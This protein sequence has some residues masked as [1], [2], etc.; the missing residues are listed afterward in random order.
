MRVG[1]AGCAFGFA[2]GAAARFR[3][4]GLGSVGR[5]LQRHRLTAPNHR[6]RVVQPAHSEFSDPSSGSGAAGEAQGIGQRAA[7]LRR[8]Q[9]G[10]DVVR[11]LALGAQGV[12]LGRAW[13][14]ALGGGGGAGVA[15]MLQLIESE[16]RVVM[17]LTG[18]RTIGEI[19]RSIL[20]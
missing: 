10:L 4:S 20:A 7:A 15:H 13:A 16:M 6:T 1:F 19:D 11:M 8:R 17:A 14:F 18:T 9:V 2:Y 12:L 3:D 5:G